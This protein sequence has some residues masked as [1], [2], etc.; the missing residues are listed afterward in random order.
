MVGLTRPLLFLYLVHHSISYHHRTPSL[1]PAESNQFIRPTKTSTRVDTVSATK[2]LALKGA[3]FA[4][5]E[6]VAAAI[7]EGVAAELADAMMAALGNR[8]EHL[9]NSWTCTPQHQTMMMADAVVEQEGPNVLAEQ[10]TDP[11][12]SPGKAGGDE[13]AGSPLP[14]SLLCLRRMV[15]SPLRRMTHPRMSPQAVMAMPFWSS[16]P[17]TI[18]CQNGGCLV[19]AP[20]AR[21]GMADASSCLHAG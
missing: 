5:S 18:P 8:F 3:S 9:S 13:A 20:R 11:P 4:T 21:R 1:A 12:H 14:A 6:E 10:E 19:D 2:R 7:R 16:F 17:S 15:P